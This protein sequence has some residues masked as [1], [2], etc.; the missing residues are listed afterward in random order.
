MHILR[1]VR[2]YF[3]RTDILFWILTLV[4]S[5]YGCLLIASQQRAGDVNFL[6]TQQLED[7]HNVAEV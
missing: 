5:V 3:L 2:D 4:A 7:N 6:K 1:S